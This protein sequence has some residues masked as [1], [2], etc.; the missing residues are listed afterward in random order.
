MLCFSQTKQ[1]ENI[2]P[3]E[4]SYG[5]MLGLLQLSPRKCPEF[6]DHQVNNTNKRGDSSTSLRFFVCG[7]SGTFDDNNCSVNAGPQLTPGSMGILGM[8]DRFL[9]WQVYALAYRNGHAWCRVL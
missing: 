7:N 8:K 6:S 3:R 1:K 5:F 4:I 9:C 2:G